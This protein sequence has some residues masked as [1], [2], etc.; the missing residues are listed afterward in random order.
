MGGAYVHAPFSLVSG[1]NHSCFYN[2]TLLTY[3]KTAL[4]V[5]C[6][7]ISGYPLHV[8]AFMTFVVTVLKAFILKPACLTVQFLQMFS[9]GVSTHSV[10]R[11]LLYITAFGKWG[12]RPLLGGSQGGR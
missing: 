8:F 12:I 5:K 4:R 1:H 11:H 10:L 3:Y 9:A 7:S 6:V 2:K